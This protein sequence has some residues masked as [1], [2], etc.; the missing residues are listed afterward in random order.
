[1][2]LTPMSRFEF[3]LVVATFAAALTVGKVFGPAA[4]FGVILSG[5]LVNVIVR[6]SSQRSGGT[7]R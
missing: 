1:M 6:L 3:W 4:G 7:N 2:P 5:S